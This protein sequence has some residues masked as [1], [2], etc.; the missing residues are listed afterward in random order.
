[1]AALKTNKNA[2][3]AGMQSI[4]TAIDKSLAI[5]TTAI[6]PIFL[7][8][9]GNLTGLRQVN[10]AINPRRQLQDLVGRTPILLYP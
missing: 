2:M 1:M 9:N 4:P 6:V 7:Q 8:E 5:R 10:F 3:A